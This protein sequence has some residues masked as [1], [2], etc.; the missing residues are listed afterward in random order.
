MKHDLVFYQR[1]T[2]CWHGFIPTHPR[3]PGPIW[4]DYGLYTN[5]PTLAQLDQVGWGTACS[6][7][8]VLPHLLLWVMTT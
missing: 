2:R 6:P 1:A 4:A 3:Q 8:A 5:K 7:E